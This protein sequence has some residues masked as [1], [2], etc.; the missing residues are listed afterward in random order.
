MKQQSIAKAS[1]SIGLAQFKS[2]VEKRA[3]EV[4]LKRQTTKTPGDAL[5]DWLQAEKEIKA[6][7]HIA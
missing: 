5:S 4:F 3:K 7:H 2:E 1:S 6:M